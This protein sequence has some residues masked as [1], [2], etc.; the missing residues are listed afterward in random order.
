MSTTQLGQIGPARMF[1]GDAGIAFLLVNEFR[2]R[3]IGRV[4]GVSRADSNVVSAVAVGLVAGGVASGAARLGSMRKHPSAAEAAMGAA[5]LK[6]TAHGIAGEWSRATPFFAGLIV[7]LLLEKSFGPAL[8]GSL[9]AVQEM[10]RGTRA[11]L[12]KARAFLGGQ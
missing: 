1:A 11:S 4:F 2:H 6:E 10:V 8:R 3:I 9:R 7:I 5:V 12:D